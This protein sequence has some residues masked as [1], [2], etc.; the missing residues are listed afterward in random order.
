MK[1]LLF[2]A[3]LLAFGLPLGVSGKVI[4]LRVKGVEIGTR[5]RTVL[6]KLGKPLSSKNGGSYP[7]DDDNRMMTLRYP[8]LIIKLIDEDERKYFF[9]ASMEVTSRR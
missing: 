4:D 9:V 6:R 2:I 7:C 1:R 8:G 5:Y 3:L